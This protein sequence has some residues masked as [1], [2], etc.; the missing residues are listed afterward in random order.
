MAERFEYSDGRTHYEVLGVGHNAGDREVEEAYRAKLKLLENATG[1]AEGEQLDPD[2][3]ARIL[4]AYRVLSHPYSRAAYDV[5]VDP[6]RAIQSPR[7]GSSRFTELEESYP[8]MRGYHRFQISSGILVAVII[9][10]LVVGIA[11]LG[12][13]GGSAGLVKWV[14]GGLF[15]VAVAAVGGV[16]WAMRDMF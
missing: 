2:E 3:A 1:P 10:A 5:S 13:V 15:V 9:L 16:V 4:E 6:A 12:M 14:W 8:S 7:E 11:I